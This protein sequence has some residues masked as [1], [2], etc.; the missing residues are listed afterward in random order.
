MYAYVEGYTGFLAIANRVTM[1]MAEKL[2]ML[3]K[4]LSPFGISQVVA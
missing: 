4:I 2:Y 1:N 3:S